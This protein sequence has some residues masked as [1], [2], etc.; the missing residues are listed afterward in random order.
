M[1]RDEII[2]GIVYATLSPPSEVRLISKS[3]SVFRNLL[4]GYDANGRQNYTAQANGS[5]PEVAIFDGAGQRVAVRSAGGYNI[6]VYDA[7]GKLVAEYAQLTPPSTAN[8]QY[9]TAN[10]QGSTKANGQ[11]IMDG[12]Q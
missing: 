5:S 6:M 2:G 4:Y 9:V 1:V 11:W 7:G 8:I 3:I 12:G 10:Y